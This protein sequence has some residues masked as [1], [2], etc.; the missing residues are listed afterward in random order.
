VVHYKN[1]YQRILLS[2]CA[3]LI[4]I[5][6][7]PAH[8]Q[9]S[10]QSGSADP[11]RIGQQYTDQMTL[12]QVTQPVQVRPSALLNAPA[13]AEN[14]RMKFGGLQIEGNNIYSDEELSKV[15]R[16]DIGSQVTLADIYK[17]AN[18]IAIKYRKAGYMLTQVVVPPQT[19]ESGVPRVR[20]VEGYVDTIRVQGDGQTATEAAMVD[21]IAQHIATNKTAVNIHDMERQLLLINDLP[22]VTARS[23]ISPSET[24]PGAAD[25]LIIVERDPFDALV[26][27][28]NYGSRFLG[29]WAANGI[30]NFNSLLGL[31][32][33]IMA[34]AVYAP[35][36]GYELLHGGL[37]YEQPIG[38]HGTRVGARFS[39]TD[40]DP[41]HTL[42][43]FDV[44]GNAKYYSA[45]V[46]HPFI[47]S[48]NETLIGQ[49]SFDWRDVKSSN[50]VEPTRRDHIRALRAHAGYSFLD[51]LLG[52][53]ANKLSAQLSK[54]LNVFGASEEG[55]RNMSRNFGD[56]QFTKADVEIERLQRVLP[57]VNLKLVG[58]AQLASDALP[59]S[60]E[61]GVGGYYSGRGYDPSEIVGDDGIS[62]Q[63]EVQWNNP[64]N[65]TIN[66]V[67]NYQ[68]YTFMD[69]GRVWNVDATTL[70]D[71]RESLVSTGLGVRVNFAYDIDMNT[72]VAFPLTRRVSSEND[73]DPRFYLSVSKKF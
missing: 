3:L 2:S 66:A 63:V 35:G 25:V 68:F 5:G 56:P 72:G 46:S 29:Q 15:Y 1:S 14:I 57:S 16:S 8:A 50:N 32:E 24:S 40:T 34:Q 4:S 27:I 45:Y 9:L 20:V 13:G 36:T 6:A 47:R 26:S 12:P 28:D 71:K 41:G 11:G 51:N 10:Q 70:D 59:S 60:E 54:G 65:S 73:K 7:A 38:S 64:I 22:G 19:I 33:Q 49:L 42:R 18:D 23:I 17:Y 21:S 55:D 37:G 48:R 39:V 30:V 62:A 43:R 53:S 69:A 31:N 67:Q 61:F 44:R 58:K 52:P